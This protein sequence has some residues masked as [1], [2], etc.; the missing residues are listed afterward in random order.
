MTAEGTVGVPTYFKTY[1]SVHFPSISHD[2]PWH[3]MLNSHYSLLRR[4][5]LKYLWFL[6]RFGDFWSKTIPVRLTL[7]RHAKSDFIDHAPFPPCWNWLLRPR[8]FL[9]IMKW[10][11]WPRNLSSHADTYFLTT[12]LS[13]YAEV[14]LL[15]TLRFSMVETVIITNPFSS[16]AT[17]NQT[18]VTTPLSSHAELDFID[19]APSH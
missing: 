2:K 18:L 17:E 6:L 11:Y 19:H 4:G 16:H 8:P 15:T 9:T 12:S 13:S 3:S 5:S 1:L 7:S 14:D 10:L